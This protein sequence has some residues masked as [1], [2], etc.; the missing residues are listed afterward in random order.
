MNITNFVRSQLKEHIRSDMLL[1]AQV[2]ANGTVR[3]H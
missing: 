3:R 2:T 1:E